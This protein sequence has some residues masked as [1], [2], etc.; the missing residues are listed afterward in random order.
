M[1]K[2]IL[3]SIRKY[4]QYFIK[5]E[6]QLTKLSSVLSIDNQTLDKFIKSYP[7]KERAYVMKY[8]HN[9]A[10][11]GYDIFETKNK[12][13]DINIP[14]EISRMKREKKWL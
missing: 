11:L 12:I 8:L 10:M 13:K 9:M 5:S 2:F 7:R 14:Y 4:L 1:F 6:L 3:K